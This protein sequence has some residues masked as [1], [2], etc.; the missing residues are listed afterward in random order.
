MQRIL[1]NDPDELNHQLADWIVENINT[2]LQ[3]QQQYSLALA[4]GDTPRQ[5]YK[6]LA[7]EPFKKRVDWEKLH[8]FWGDERHVPFEDEKNNARMAFGTLLNKVPVL[9]EHIHRINTSLTPR[10]AAA[11]YEKI[12]HRFFTNPEKT[13]DLVLL[14]LGKDAHTLSLFPGSPIITEK[15]KWVCPVEKDDIAR[16]TL[17]APVINQSNR[18]A[19]LVSGKEKAPALKNVFGEETDPMRFPAQIIQPLNNELYWFIDREAAINA[20][21]T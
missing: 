17:T 21:D 18:I 5:L 6:L 16:I 1:A 20:W 9:P 14:G 11:S 19:F 2:T 13:F 12:L 4:G 7:A 10:E 8:F 3:K 15:K